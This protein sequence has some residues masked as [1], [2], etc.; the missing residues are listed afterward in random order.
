MAQQEEEVEAEV[1]QAEVV[2]SEGEKED[3]EVEK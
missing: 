3:D 1:G 2:N